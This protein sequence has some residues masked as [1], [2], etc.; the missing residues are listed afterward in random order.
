MKKRYFGAEWTDEVND[1]RILMM[2]HD[3]IV[4]SI[5]GL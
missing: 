5:I 1:L 2:I 3:A 4:C